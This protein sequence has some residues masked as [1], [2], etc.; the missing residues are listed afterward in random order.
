MAFN[1][2]YVLVKNIPLNYQQT[3]IETTLRSFLESRQEIFG[4]L[5]TIKISRNEIEECHRAYITYH[6]TNI[7]GE[8][9]RYLHN[10]YILGSYIDARNIFMRFRPN[11]LFNPNDDVLYSEE[12]KRIP[13]RKVFTDLE[14]EY[15]DVFEREIN[16]SLNNNS[17]GSQITSLSNIV[18]HGINIRSDEI[19][20]PVN[21]NVGELNSRINN[22]QLTSNNP[23]SRL[24]S[25]SMYRSLG[26]QYNNSSQINRIFSIPHSSNLTLN[27]NV[28]EIYADAMRSVDAGRSVVNTRANF[29]CIRCKINFGQSQISYEAHVQQCLA[30]EKL[31]LSVK[32]REA[33]CM[34]CFKLF[35]QTSTEN[36]RFLPCGHFIHTDCYI[37]L[38]ENR[39]KTCP[40]CRVA[41]PAKWKGKIYLN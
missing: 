15:W 40:L 7:H 19:T 35:E 23:I 26:S 20:N 4:I 14:G 27:K 1:S 34:L 31:S 25:N 41:I 2:K 8:I 22:L 9:V 28:A 21:E 13:A 11:I 18:P 10:M 39:I 12:N 30:D 6:D 16:D 3:T 37:A 32:I 29:K 36:V 5:K 17:I 24:N 33:K 38:I